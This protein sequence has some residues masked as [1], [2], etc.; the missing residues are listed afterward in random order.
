M[1]QSKGKKLNRYHEGQSF[2]EENMGK[3]HSESY[4]KHRNLGMFL[5]R[6]CSVDSVEN[7]CYNLFL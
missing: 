3:L 7:L 1:K 5:G 2:T 6:D 4:S